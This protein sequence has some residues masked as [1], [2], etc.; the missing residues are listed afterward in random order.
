MCTSR[1]F[2][3]GMVALWLMFGLPVSAKTPEGET[4]AQSGL[5]DV[6]KQD[7]VTK[8]L[9]GVCVALCEAQGYAGGP[10]T[11]ESHRRLLDNYDKLRKPGDRDLPCAPPSLKSEPD[12]APPPP[13]PVVQVCP[14]W[15]PAEADAVDGVLSDGSTAVGWAPKTTSGSACSTKP[16]NPYIQEASAT[17]APSEVSYLQAVNVST[18]FWQLHQCKYRKMV[19]NQP[20]ADVFLSVEFG[21]LTMEQLAACEADIAARQ[22]AMDICQ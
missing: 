16:D 11:K 21:T 9:Y 2:Q 12:P 6:L 18:Q 8:G 17:I 15:T 3:C 20:L 7:G 19:P 4:P 22:L 10:P 5:C 14:C 13:P 1:L